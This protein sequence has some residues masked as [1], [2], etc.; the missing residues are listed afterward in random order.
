MKI[1][2]SHNI[3]DL[4]YFMHDNKIVS[5]NVHT[6]SANCTSRAQSVQYIVKWGHNESL[7]LTSEKVF[8]NK[9]SLLDSL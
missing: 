2:T 6:I 7:I 8:S 4:V 3:G 1:E 9:K 5:A